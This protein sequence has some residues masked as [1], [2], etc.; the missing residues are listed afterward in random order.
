MVTYT[1]HLLEIWHLTDRIKY[2]PK[3]SLRF[4]KTKTKLD[5]RRHGK[6]D[7]YTAL[8][9][10]GCSSITKYSLTFFFEQLKHCL[11]SNQNQTHKLA[12]AWFHHQ[13]LTKA[14]TNP[15]KNKYPENR[16]STVKAEKVNYTILKHYKQ[17]TN[18][19]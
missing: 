11:T 14:L 1:H 19:T 7:R 8:P 5:E 15:N 2:P 17:E 12:L 6:W 4:W 16:T 3:W 10:T 13:I 18:L 9:K